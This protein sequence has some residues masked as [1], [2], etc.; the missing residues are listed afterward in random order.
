M[1]FFKGTNFQTNEQAQYTAADIQK[2]NGLIAAIIALYE[3]FAAAPMDLL[4]NLPKNLAR[5]ENDLPEKDLAG[6]GDK[7]ELAVL[8]ATLYNLSVLAK[9]DDADGTLL[10]AQKSTVRSILSSKGLDD[11]IY[12]QIK[13]SMR[14]ILDHFDRQVFLEKQ[15]FISFSN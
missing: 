14:D 4:V 10:D 13:D 9:P 3:S 11:G 6:H 7:N 2:Q 15:V 1:V 12:Q 8:K 5:A